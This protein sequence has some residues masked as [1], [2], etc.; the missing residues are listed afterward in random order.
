MGPITA[1]NCFPLEYGEGPVVPE[2]DD[3]PTVR[4]KPSKFSG[5]YSRQEIEEAVE[6]GRKFQRAHPIPPPGSLEAL[7]LRTGEDHDDSADAAS[8]GIQRENDHHLT[9]PVRTGDPLA[10][11][12]VNSG[13]QKSS[14]THKTPERSMLAP[15]SPR[16]RQDVTSNSTAEEKA[17]NAAYQRRYQAK[18]AIARL[19]SKGLTVPPELRQRALD[20][21][22]VVPGTQRHQF[23]A[24]NPVTAAD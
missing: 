18:K 9:K 11:P 20:G 13:A 19:E 14:H 16:H 8:Y 1:F 22:T 21:V 6:A 2:R 10:R 3:L 23:K 24:Q 5:A 12:R 4:I 15:A 7:F 17:E